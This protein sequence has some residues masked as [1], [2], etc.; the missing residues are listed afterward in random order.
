[1]HQKKVG[2]LI[3]ISLILMSS[4]LSVSAEEEHPAGY[5]VYEVQDNQATD[6]W[7][8]IA[9]GDYLQGAISKIRAGS[10][11]KYVTCSGTTLAH[12]ACDRVYVRTYLDQSNNGV[13]GWWT[14][15]YWTGENFNNSTAHVSVAD[16]E[17]TRDKYYRVQ[18]AHSVTE[19]E[20]T[21]VTTTCTDAL[22]FD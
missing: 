14:V 5:H 2:A 21:E 8:G 7:Y 1:M 3:G 9:R 19:G 13:D 10:A 16:Y 12:R 17:I 18:G 11:S 4:C 20:T 15:N 6:T 22:Y